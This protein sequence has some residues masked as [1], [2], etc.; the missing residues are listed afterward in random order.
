M[1]ER[2]LGESGLKVSTVGLGCMGM[3]DKLTKG[4]A[5]FG[6]LFV[7]GALSPEP[8]P[9]PLFDVL[10]KGLTIRGDKMLDRYVLLP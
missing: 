5:G 3:S 2:E 7:Y 10:I 1:T 9:L 6:F 8:T 4:M